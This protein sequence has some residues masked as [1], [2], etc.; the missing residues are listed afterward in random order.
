MHPF[1]LSFLYSSMKYLKK[2]WIIIV[3]CIIAIILAI[4]YSLGYRLSADSGISRVGTLSLI[5]IPK[6]TS[7]YVDQ[8]LVRTT[9]KAG[10]LNL[11]LVHGSHPVIVSLPGDYPWSTTSQIASTQKTTINPIFIPMRPAVTPLT[12][13]DK[14]AALAAVAS[15]TLPTRTNPIVLT[16]GCSVVYVENNQVI[17]DATSTAMTTP[18][19]VPPPYLCIGGSCAATIIFAPVAPLTSV[20]LFPHRQDALVVSFNNTLYAISLDPRAPQ[21]FAPILAA[22]HPGI[23]ALPDGTIVI[24]NEPAAYSVQL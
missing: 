16:G 5:N 10:T 15:S 7:V 8:A 19:C 1:L 17:Q 2:Y 4:G 12:G 23:G 9:T 14:T 20:H 18:G 24:Y 13:D 6:G 11:E 21:F 22:T 3:V